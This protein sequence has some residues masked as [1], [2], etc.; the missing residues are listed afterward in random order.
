MKDSEKN[1]DPKRA[2]KRAVADL[3]CAV[4]KLGLEAAQ[5]VFTELMEEVAG[6]DPRTCNHAG[7]RRGQVFDFCPTCLAVRRAPDAP[8]HSCEICQAHGA[9]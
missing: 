5:A 8:W 3:R 6:F 7:Y 2:R 4:K 9:W 1:R